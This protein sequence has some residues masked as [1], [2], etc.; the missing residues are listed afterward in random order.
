MSKDV[1]QHLVGKNSAKEAWETI[2]ILHKRHDRVKKAH[3]QSLM[4]SYECLKMD[5]SETVDQFAT[6]LKTLV[7]GIRSYGSTLE[8]VAIV[9]RFLR[10][11]PSRYIQIVTSIEQCLDLKTLMVKDLVARFKDHGERIRLSFGDSKGSEH[12]MLTKAQWIA[13]SKEKQGGHTSSG[14]KKGKGKQRSA[15][16]N[17]DDSDEEDAPAPP[18]RKFDIK[19]V[20]CCKC[21]LLG[22]FK[23]NCD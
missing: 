14:K 13:L 7:N 2:K 1:L 10:A 17:F 20:R 18:R 8:E 21:G 12:L 16:K 4:R 9:R 5:E 6:R 3:L 11:A 23:A 22:H 19:K 15:R